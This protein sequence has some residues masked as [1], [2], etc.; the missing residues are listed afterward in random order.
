MRVH[1]ATGR[2]LAA[3][4]LAATMVWGC[5][6]D[7]IA[8]PAPPPPG[9]P[10][11]QPPTPQKVTQPV[12]LPAYVAAHGGLLAAPELTAYLDSLANRLARHLVGRHRNIRV[13]ILDTPVPN[14]FS[15]TA[16]H[17]HPSRGLL[18][19]VNSRAELAGLLAH[20]LGHLE[21]G[22]QPRQTLSPV[23]APLALLGVGAASVDA[24]EAGGAY[25]P[26]QERTADGI[27]ERLLQ[28]EGFDLNATY[29]LRQ[30][31]RQ[32]AALEKELAQGTGSAAPKIGDRHPWAFK[33]MAKTDAAG[34]H[35]LVDRLAGLPFGDR[36]DQGVVRGRRFDH[37]VL[38]LGLQVPHGFGLINRPQ[39]MFALGPRQ[40]RL[41]ADVAAIPAATD[42]GRYLAGSWARKL[43]LRGVERTTINGIDAALGQSRAPT[44]QGVRDVTL[45]VYR[46]SKTQVF[47]LLF[48]TRPETTRGFQAGILQ[49][50]HSVRRLSRAE[51]AGLRPL[52]LEIIKPGPG[53]TR[54]SLVERMALPARAADWFDILNGLEKDATLPKGQSLKIVVE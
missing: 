54:Q 49:T 7:P 48:V 53:D 51:I 16:G 50:M 29:R 17:L 11:A 33:Q 21:A 6:L 30:R 46:L 36:V 20:Q 45:V 3:T 24:V 14:L 41:Q 27:A 37:P 31:L 42:T 8:P 34:S 40:A 2:G 10:K 39:A 35:D 18:A 22:H 28:A 9:R 43:P 44:A 15:S 25:T 47:R 32:L 4:L 26:E 5:A 23:E 12:P 1:R 13:G 38:K 52:R 19:L